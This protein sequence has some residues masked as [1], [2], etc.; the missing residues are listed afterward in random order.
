MLRILAVLSFLLSS[1]AAFS[2]ELPTVRAAVLK[3]GTVNWELATIKK[4][5]LDTKH[6]FV[7][8]IR[9]YADNG[10][11]RI[12]VEGNEADTAVADWIWLAR[13]R[14]AG[15]DYVFL[16]YSRAVGGIVVPENSTIKSLS[17][18][19]GKKIGI[20]GGPLDKSWLIL[21]AY[22]LATYG[23]DLKSD[24]Q[25]VFGAP[26]L[27]FRTATSGGLDAALNYWHFLAKMKAAGMRELVSVEE[28]LTALQ[29]DPQ[30]PLIGYYFKQSFL[31]QNP[32][33]AQSFYNASQDAKDLLA[34][35]PD[36][37]EE[38][39]PT[40]NAKTDAEFEQLKNDWIAGIPSRSAVNQKSAQDI[41]SL[42]QKL[43]GAE[44][45]GKASNVPPGLFADVK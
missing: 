20:A 16:P 3:I 42:M 35:S 6:G 36:I 18:L 41:L 12:A 23:F 30:I 27:I 25:Q 17:D 28:A 13:Q 5:G 31:D 26:P 1:M 40:M 8:E 14:A 4:Y 15:K 37:W 22:A 39:R 29:L 21:Q 9:P 32:E 33:I 45:V 2:D 44:L 43:G 38:L 11:T 24:T 10:A 34:N 7:L 19:S